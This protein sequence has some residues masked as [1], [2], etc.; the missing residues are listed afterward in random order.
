MAISGKFVLRIPKSIHAQAIGVA[1]SEGVSLN[2]WLASIVSM[3]V[4]RSEYGVKVVPRD[5]L[6]A[7][8][9]D[10]FCEFPECSTHE[11]NI[12]VCAACDAIYAARE[13]LKA[14]KPCPDCGYKPGERPKS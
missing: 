11:A 3:A 12:G 9:I 7:I 14:R 6:E 5:R 1:Q 2:H 4:A 13:A 10:A 8:A